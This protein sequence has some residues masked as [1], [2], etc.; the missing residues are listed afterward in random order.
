[1]PGCQCSVG[2]VSVCVCTSGGKQVHHGA[3]PLLPGVRVQAPSFPALPPCPR[4]RPLSPRVRAPPCVLSLR[5]P[6]TLTLVHTVPR[7]YR[8][9]TNARAGS[10]PL[11]HAAFRALPLPEHTSNPMPVILHIPS[12]AQHAFLQCMV[13]ASESRGGVTRALIAL[14]LDPNTDTSTS[15][16]RPSSIYG[17]ALLRRVKACTY[18]VCAA[19]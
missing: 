13:Q 6:V 12:S 7:M 14:L 18:A 17:T 15:P 3:V 4:S 5:E 10:A 2:L 16:P 8:I 1:M 9:L 19:P 11:K